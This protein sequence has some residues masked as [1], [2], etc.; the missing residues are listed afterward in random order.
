MRYSAVVR[1]AL[2]ATLHLSLALM[3]YPNPAAAKQDCSQFELACASPSELEQ[4]CG[5]GAG[6]CANSE[7][8]KLTLPVSD[9]ANLHITP[10]PYR[11]NE[12]IKKA[13]INRP[14]AVWSKCV[15]IHELNHL[16]DGSEEGLYG[17]WDSEAQSYRQHLS[18]LSE[19]ERS[20][21]DRNSPPSNWRSWDCTRLKSQIQSVKM[22]LSINLCRGEYELEHVSR[23]TCIQRCKKIN[24]DSAK[25]NELAD[26]YLKQ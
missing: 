12:I 21:C 24:N 26:L 13:Y 2:W 3:T 8:C 16:E 18:C 17:M 20:R 7:S 23:T 6:G 19:Y 5:K 9:C 10:G 4:A 14:S 11:L 1:I 15:L 22:G 25:C